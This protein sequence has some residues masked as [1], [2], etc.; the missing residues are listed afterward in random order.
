MLRA[1]SA[2]LLIL[3]CPAGLAD[4]AQG[5]YVAGGLMNQQLKSRTQSNEVFDGLQVTIDSSSSRYSTGGTLLAGYLLTFGAGGAALL[6]AGTDLGVN[7]AFSAH[8]ESAPSNVLDTRWKVSR[9]WFLAIKPGWRLGDQLMAYLSF[10]YHVADVDFSG[11][12]QFDTQTSRR[13]SVRTI[14]G[15]GIGLGLQGPLTSRLFVR[16]EVEKIRFSRTSFDY[17]P[18]GSTGADFV[19][20]HS[21]RPEAIVG[22]LIVGYRF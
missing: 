2:L 9:D 3:W 16:G 8:G 22:R 15:A 19:S 21:I 12:A 7:S 4:A 6:E 18:A 17:T 10:A 5:F 20:M 14:G 11:I 13:A 1:L